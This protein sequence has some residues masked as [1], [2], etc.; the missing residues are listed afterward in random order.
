MVELNDVKNPETINE[1]EGIVRY[2]T[3]TNEK[4]IYTFKNFLPGNYIVR[5]YFGNNKN[6]IVVKQYS[7]TINAYSYNGEDYQATN[8]IGTYGASKLY[9][10]DA[11][12]DL[13]IFW[14]A[15]N[16]E[17]K[18]STGTENSSRRIQVSNNVISF[19][20]KT[21]DLLNDL[22][23]GADIEDDNDRNS[24]NGNLYNIINNT[25][26]FASTPNFTLTVEKTQTDNENKN[27]TQNNKFTEYAVSNMNFGIAEVPVT[28]IDLQKHIKSYIITDSAGENVIAKVEK[29]GDN[30]KVKEGNVLPGE[31]DGVT[32]LDTSI[33]EEKLQGAKLQV[34]YEVSTKID[35]QKDFRSGTGVKPTITALADFIDND[36][37]Y[38]K[39]LGENDKYWEIKTSEDV[40]KAFE[41]YH[42]SYSV[43]GEV[44]KGTIDPEHIVH[45]SKVFAKVGNP[46]LNELGG[47]CEIILEKTLSSEEVTIGDII[48]SNINTYEY[49]NN[50][51]ILGL[52]YSNTETGATEDHPFRDRVR[53]LDKYIILPG[54]KHDSAISETITIHPPTGDI[55]LSLTYY[56]VTAISLS[57]FAL[58]V[59]AI[60]K[61]VVKGK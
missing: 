53:R 49:N 29:D 59:F 26:M 4:G 31:K 8:N 10:N 58:G 1:N 37:S 46:I 52:A 30:W 32:I 11:N 18:I 60:K 44:P 16:E 15:Y 9:V 20:D 57:V 23:D 12:G 41:D 36:L 28:T 51:E 54:T 34:T 3:T 55:G 22:R 50:V 40:K 39:E 27:A 13:D 42:S 25:Y 19:S 61:F 33:E 7:D 17:N 5:Y 24:K 47:K 45:T 38:N 43:I 21:M 6:T 48:T 2:R 35:I 56:I 14:Y